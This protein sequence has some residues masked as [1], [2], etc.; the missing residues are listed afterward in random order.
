MESNVLTDKIRGL[1]WKYKNKLKTWTCSHENWTYY[2]NG[3]GVYV[4]KC[5][6]CGLRDWDVHDN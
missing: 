2:L 6:R 4:G 3:K 5:S 1:F